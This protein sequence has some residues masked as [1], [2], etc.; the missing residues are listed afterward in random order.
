[1]K[2]ARL[3][4]FLLACS[5][6]AGGNH[7]ATGG[8]GGDDEGTGGSP[9]T[10][11]SPGKKDAAPPEPDAAP[12]IDTGGG[13]AGPPSTADCTAGASTIFCNTLAPLPK[14]IK[15]T[16]LFPAAPD[17]SKRPASLREYTPEPALW[18]DG[19]EKQR[20]LLLPQGTKIDN[21][22]PKRWGFPVGTVFIK[23]FFDDG[24][25]KPRPIETRFIRRIAGDDA[26]VQYDY[27]VYKWK[28]D[29][30]DA[31]LLDIEG[32]RTPVTIT[33]KALGAPFS[34]DIPSRD[35][36][37]Q[38]HDANAKVAGTF[39]GFDEIRLGSQLAA[40]APLFTQPPPAKPATITDP[41][42]RLQRI[43]RFVYGNCVHCHN[44]G[45]LVDLHPEMFV[46]NTVGKMADASG[47][48]PPAGYLRVAPGKPEMS[49]VFVETRRTML[50]T[51]LKPMPPV[52]VAVP[53][54]DPLADLKAWIMALPAK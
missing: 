5:S 16:G 15:E 31:D 52:G 40:L 4:I 18:S 41:D 48:A 42:A 8:S 19:L 26:F 44:G 32:K 49:I 20:F 22:N 30:T 38:C 43:L 23:T 47:I 3:L 50:A 9:A 33:I 14:T 46:A 11:G 45:R 28:D 27:N 25:A 53:Q 13:E 35:D 21:G 2:K 10:G 12:G 1:M 6:P 7:P 39:I 17:F 24:A 36:C 37:G 54:A 29:G 34:H 51:G